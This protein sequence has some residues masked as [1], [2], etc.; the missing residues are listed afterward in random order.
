MISTKGR[1]AIRLMVDLARQEKERFTPLCEVADRQCI[2]KLYLEIILK[3]LVAAKYLVGKSGKS[4]GYKLTKDPKKITVLEILE[5]M[6]GT[7]APVACLA[8]GAA[9]CA[10]RKKCSTIAMWTEYDKMT[11][12]FFGKRTIADLT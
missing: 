8:K 2:S 11:K 4:G 12:E 1:Y 10:F 7:V 9:P 6:E 3:K 5:L